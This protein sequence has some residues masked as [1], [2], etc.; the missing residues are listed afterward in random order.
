MSMR[1][2]NAVIKKCVVQCFCVRTPEWTQVVP[3]SSQEHPKMVPSL[4]KMT[5]RLLPDSQIAPVF[6][7]LVGLC[8]DLRTQWKIQRNQWITL[9]FSNWKKAP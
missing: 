8:Q 9:V 5:P 4:Q 3:E 1:S 2:S 6:S 7:E